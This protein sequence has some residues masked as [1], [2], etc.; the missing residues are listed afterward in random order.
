MLALRRLAPFRCAP[1]RKSFSVFKGFLREY[2][3][4][5]KH[6][7]IPTQA[8]RTLYDARFPG[9]VTDEEWETWMT[10]PGMPKWTLGTA[11]PLQESVDRVAQ[12]W[13]TD[14][15]AADAA[16][17]SL[18]SFITCQRIALLDAILAEQGRREKAATAGAGGAGGEEKEA[19]ASPAAA[20][21][22]A[23]DT[24]RRMDE[25]YSLSATR[26]AEIRFRWQML[27]LAAGFE[28]IVPEVQA[29]LL[30]QGRMKYVRPLYRSL[31]ATPFGKDA[32]VTL[33][34][35]NRSIYHPIASK[36]LSADLGVA[37]SAKE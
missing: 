16:A 20:A 34:T 29:F 11:G 27:C 22:P 4:A 21:W 33:F 13:I 3:D 31:F 28:D 36:M 7:S 24:L 37:D 5:Y 23:L 25:L 9:A 2:V 6:Q 19:A 8:L 30:E 1:L 35:E 12:V 18:D 32:A 14:G 15:A 10:A 26:N 17:V